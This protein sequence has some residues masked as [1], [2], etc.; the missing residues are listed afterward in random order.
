[1]GEGRCRGTLSEQT[2]VSRHEI[3]KVR[4]EKSPEV[5][6]AAPARSLSPSHRTQLGYQPPPHPRTQTVSTLWEM[7]AHRATRSRAQAVNQAVSCTAF[8]SSHTAPSHRGT[9]LL[10]DHLGEE[11][12]FDE[13]INSNEKRPDRCEPRDIHP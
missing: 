2:P 12:A 8:L 10:F 6:S 7:P 5:P 11:N 13:D 3:L 9:R 4:D 1:M